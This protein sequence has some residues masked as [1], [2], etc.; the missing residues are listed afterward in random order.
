[1]RLMRKSFV[2]AALVLAAAVS[3]TK[4][5][6]NEE[7]LAPKQ[8]YV[9]ITLSAK[10]DV[11]SKA[12]LN[13]KQ[14]VWEVGEEVAV[15]PGT[16]TSPEKF[17]VKTVDGAS[18][19]ITGS[20]PEGTTTLV[21]AYPYK[22]VV[23]C[24]GGVV[25]MKIADQTVS[26]SAIVAPDA[27]SSVAYFASIDAT[28]T[29]S[30]TVA[31][32]SFKVAEE[33]VTKVTLAP[34]TGNFGGNVDVTVGAEAAPAVS[35]GDA[36]A[37]SVTCEAGFAAGTE[38]FAAVAPG[39]FVGLSVT[40][41]KAGKNG[42]KTS[43]KGASLNRNGVLALGDV[44]T[45]AS[46]KYGVI[47]NAEEL[48]EFLAV[49]AD[50]V[51]GDE[52]ELG[53]DIDC[54]GKTIVPAASFV[55]V[56]DGKNFS[57]KNWTASN[58]L[59]ATNNG[60][61][62]NIVIDKT[63][64]INWTEEI[65]DMTGVAFI[66]SKNNGT[67]KNCS[68][69]GDIT[70]K[71]DTAGRI[72]CAG[73]VG[74]SPKGLV[75]GCKFSGSINVELSGTS[76]SCSA[77]AGV[78][79]RVGHADMADKVIVDNCENTGSIKFKFSGAS[80]AMKKFGIG[81]VVGQTPSVANAPTNHGIIQNCIN[82]GDVEWQ[83]PEGGSGSYP[84]LGGVVGI[85]E[86]QLKSSVNYG[87]ITFIGNKYNV[88]VTDAS[89]GGVAGY[90]TL[91]A[92]GCHNHGEIVIDSAIAGGTSMA[93]SGGNTDWS[94]FGGVFGNAG[95]YAANNT[96]CADQGILVENCS[97]DANFTLK[98][99]MVTS[100]GPQMCF[101]GVIGVST[102]N[103]KDCENK[104]N[105]VFETQTK[106]MNAGGIVGFLAA[107]MENCTN[108]GS[109]TLN[110]AAAHH[111]AVDTK[112]GKAITVQAYFGGIFGMATTGSIIKTVKNTGAVTLE[113]LYNCGDPANTTYNI[114]S[115][116]G[117]INGSYKGG[118]VIT[119]AENTGI[120]TNNADIPVCLGGLSGAF[121]GTMT[122]GKN[123]GQVVNASSWCSTVDG[124]Q[125]EVGGVAGYANA[126]FTNC[127]NTGSLTNGP[128]DGAIGG[129]VGSHGE[130]TKAVYEWAGCKVNCSISGNAVAGSV[131]GKFRYA[132][133]NAEAPTVINLGSA[134]GAFTI[135]GAIASKPLVGNIKGHTVV[136]VN[137]VVNGVPMVSFSE[138][139]E[140]NKFTY[141]GKEY[142]IVKMKD[143]RW[144]MAKNL[145]YLPAGMTPATDLTAV[146]A[147]VFAPI[148]VKADQ[149]GAEFTTDEA[150]ISS[151]G[152]LYQAE[153]ALGLKVGDITTVAQAKAL[154]KAQGICPPGWHVPGQ[155]EILALV[156][157]SAGATT[158]TSA[159]YYDGSKGS[160]ALL[161][162]DGFGMDAYGFVS[163]QDNTKTSGTLIG[164]V[165]AY[166]D[167]LSSSMFCGSTQFNTVTYNVSGDETSGLK[168]IQF[169][170]FMPMTNKATEAEYSCSG[171]NVSYRIAGPLRCIRD[172]E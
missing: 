69:A 152:Y 118:I 60:T 135:D 41:L 103:M 29:F 114:L 39:D 76:A 81:G 77:I 145:A 158:N 169:A 161:N 144:W 70:V 72:Y 24:S 3:C 88:A 87:K 172:A 21:A 67:V 56:F 16:A 66:V 139:L 65:P 1:M 116:V 165:K 20:V 22:N 115:Y 27:L 34:V 96:N 142:P 146:T 44:T 99:Y 55:G 31:L 133:T 109:V 57:I 98:C 37:V 82:R 40:S 119:D 74:E 137:V 73:V 50:Y 160:L 7:V 128:E 101:G 123:S 6:A 84:A 63:C 83:Y 94:S 117:G 122:N 125:P 35:A 164:W 64:S 168:N 120:I 100:G 14:V 9:E 163:I 42:T 12:S 150:V 132:P 75:D 26:G 136:P 36:P 28:P 32:I 61:I 47:T 48:Q 157:V 13:G 19:T 8:G 112:N 15:F 71:T 171:S 80:G 17:T 38:Y 52:V 97:N 10:C 156:G 121:N 126:T 170:G 78:A 106:T 43:E 89:I 86:G 18:V 91:G 167:K 4:E 30:N 147:G 79:G 33:G 143:G 129:L 68:V 138:D 134:S 45:G 102:A 25:K 130:Y 148:R 2:F 155:D 124:K 131:L 46:W 93:Q 154:E 162:A 140:N 113:N 85:V 105:I 54:S 11:D 5:I 90:V 23:S 149:T 141:A 110:G 58:A 53:N 104:G 153:V 166:P 62:Q 59:F 159:P 51:E 49:A 95:P 92:S 151:N 111:T 108:S 127:E 107:D